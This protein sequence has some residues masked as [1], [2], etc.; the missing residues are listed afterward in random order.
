MSS[1]AETRDAALSDIMA[2][3]RSLAGPV[4]VSRDNLE[5]IKEA[6]VAFAARTELWAEDQFPAPTDGKVQ[7]RYLITKD[8]DDSYA[9]YLNVMHKGKYAKPHNHT[10]WACV[11]AVEGE[12]YN[13][14]YTPDEEGPLEPGQRQ[15]QLT[16]TI[17]VKPG[18][19]IALLPDD[20]HAIAINEGSSTRHLHLYG[21]ALE[22]LDGRILWQKDLKSC[23]FYDMDI[24]TIK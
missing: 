3:V 23:N 20:I 2:K 4:E 22:T 8:D 21:R 15:I 5:K 19:G 10:T 9:L 17:V 16:D 18:Q 1:V 12:E 6:M 24:K 13:Y 11:T 14:V 7:N